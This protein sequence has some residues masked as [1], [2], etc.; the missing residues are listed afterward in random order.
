[1]LAYNRTRHSGCKIAVQSYHSPL[2]FIQRTSQ[3]Q[4]YQL[5][6]QERWSK[7]YRMRETFLA[8]EIS[9]GIDPHNSA[10]LQL[11]LRM[12]KTGAQLLPLRPEGMGDGRESNEWRNTSVAKKSCF[13]DPKWTQMEH[14]EHG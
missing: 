9:S 13:V 10:T 14:G 11:R 8:C 3:W 7:R 6:L 2:I 4:R 1:M 12:F 5:V